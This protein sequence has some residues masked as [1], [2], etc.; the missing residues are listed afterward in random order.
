MIFLCITIP[1]GIALRPWTGIWYDNDG[2][3]SRM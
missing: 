2:E 3:R 1:W